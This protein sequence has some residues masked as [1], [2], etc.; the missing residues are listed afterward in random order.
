MTVSQKVALSLLISVVLFAGFTVLAF[1]GLF[2]LVEARFYNPSVVRGLTEE[3]NRDTSTIEDF[4]AE[5]QSRF[6]ATLR[7]SPVK[8]SFLPIQ[9]GEDIFE[10]T[11]IYGL[12][13]ESLAGLQWVRF[14]DAGGSRIHFSTYTQD[15]L[16]QDRLS[17]VYRDYTNNP[18]NLP[19]EQIAVSNQ[20][21]TKITFDEGGGRILF[22]FPF[23]D[24][25][26]VYRGTAL[27]SL[28]LRAVTEHLIH[29]GRI[30]V[31]E[32]IT[33]LNEP[34]GIVSGIPLLLQ[35]A[36]LPM[37]ASIWR[38]GI[39]N[40]SPLDSTD[41]GITL[42][43]ISSK[44]LQG[45][46][47]GR[48]V[49]ESVFSFPLAMK[50]I[51][52]ASFF[53]TLYLIIF[54]AFNT[55]QDTITVVENR[56]K[57]LRLSFIEQYYDQKEDLDTD[58]RNR[59]LEKRREEIR[60]EIKRGLGINRELDKEVDTLI[61]NFWDE[62][63]AAT[64]D[65]R[66]MKAP[67]GVDEKKL[68]AILD[69]IF[70]ASSPGSFSERLGLPVLENSERLTPEQESQNLDN[71]T[72]KEWE[73][74]EPANAEN[75]L[76][77]DL[78]ED[79]EE[80][81]ETENLDEIELGETKTMEAVPAELV[82]TGEINAEEISAA[83]AILARNPQRK[84]SNI[85]L[86][87]GDDDIPYIVESSG[88]EL[89]DEDIDSELMTPH[90]EE[91]SAVM[92]TKDM[93]EP[94][95]DDNDIEELEE[96]EEIEELDTVEDAEP[97]FEDTSPPGQD[98]DEAAS[99]IEFSPLPES[100]VSETGEDLEIVS[101]FADIFSDFSD[102]DTEAEDQS[103]EKTQKKPQAKINK[104]G[105]DTRGTIGLEKLDNNL[106]MSLVYRSFFVANNGTPEFLEL[107]EEPLPESPSL[108]REGVI[109]ERDGLHFINP[110]AIPA[111]EEK[112]LDPD[113]KNLVDSVS[114]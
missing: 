82:K 8:R 30:K 47:V 66:K 91:E 73:E 84:R 5:L 56:L 63:L 90:Q 37:I 79:L 44:T 34:G 58:Q 89:V 45:I 103:P 24:S 71:I 31:G 111:P 77:N 112:D 110:A 72:L 80:F 61:D 64:V 29:E 39:L 78:I 98:L 21:N 83:E 52:L 87:F 32:N 99:E 102:T 81:V 54:L 59:E 15:I 101:P 100:E 49:D 65:H 55:K 62:L 74:Y 68:R 50:I 9:V 16:Y 69:R 53:L 14:I 26:D 1:T 75:D 10:R 18:E 105:K 97:V 88:L 92:G 95:N 25:F 7:E 27:F 17:V 57:Q 42:A 107:Q 76:E 23:Y 36:L 2:D 13:V 46:F 38:E 96:L 3:I 40:L 67:A 19:Y 48:L 113:F 43:L 28:S 106:S 6:S 86:A 60:A 51:L 35:N 12:L 104:G 114:K 94:N 85:R 20:G 41:S 70:N 4:M 11:R 22:S 93:E 109:A 33:I 108:P